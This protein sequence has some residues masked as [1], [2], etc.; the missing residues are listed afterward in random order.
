MKSLEFLTTVNIGSINE[1]IFEKATSYYELME[2]ADLRNCI[3]L[4]NSYTSKVSLCYFLLE[5]VYY[6]LIYISYFNTLKHNFGL[7][8]IYTYIYIY[9]Y[10]EKNIM[11]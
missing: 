8:E 3:L 1:D 10:I 2:S 5:L 6:L 9:I 4:S 11:R 7:N